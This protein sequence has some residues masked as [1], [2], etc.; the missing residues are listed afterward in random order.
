MA[1]YCEI[2]GKKVLTGFKISHSHRKSKRTWKPNVQRVRVL[3]NG[4]VKRM[5]VCTR[6]LRPNKVN[7]DI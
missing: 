4:K 7:R 5:N 2:S 3:V 1:N 6:A